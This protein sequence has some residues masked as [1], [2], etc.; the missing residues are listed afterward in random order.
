MGGLDV[1]VFTGGIGENSD[2]TRSGV[3]EELEF[4]GIEI[5]PKINKGL[6]GEECVI[7]TKDSR[8]KVIV[9][10]TNEELMIAIDTQKIIYGKD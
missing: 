7:S 1:L 10:P 6:K 9:V 5:D 8:V 3:C 2:L 4:M